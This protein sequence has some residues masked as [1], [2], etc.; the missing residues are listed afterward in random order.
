MGQPYKIT[1][2]FPGPVKQ[3]GSIFPGE[4]PAAP[5]RILFMDADP[6]QE[7]RFAVDQDVGPSGCQCPEAYPVGNFVIRGANDYPAKMRILR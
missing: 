2:Q 4:G 1:S 6:F 7:Y 3:H 5:H